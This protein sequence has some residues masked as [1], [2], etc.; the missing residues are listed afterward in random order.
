MLPFATAAR[1]AQF[2]RIQW[3]WSLCPNRE[4]KVFEKI[5][6]L[7]RDEAQSLFRRLSDL[8]MGW[9]TKDCISV[10]QLGQFHD[11]CRLVSMRKAV[12]QKEYFGGLQ[13]FAD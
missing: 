12:V 8:G 1:A 6:D 4:R 2:R 13:S 9:E 10:A 7:L 3:D 5:S 11:R